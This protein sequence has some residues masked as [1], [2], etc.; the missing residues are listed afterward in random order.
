VV[1]GPGKVIDAIKA[2]Q[3]AARAIDA[4]IR[5]ANGQEPW[6]APAEERMDIPLKGDEEPGDQPRISMPKTPSKIRRCD[7]REVELGYTLEMALAE[8][9]RCL[10]CDA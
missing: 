6:I 9:C 3:T 4:A 5:A 8:A 2:G 1:T 10:R 7:F